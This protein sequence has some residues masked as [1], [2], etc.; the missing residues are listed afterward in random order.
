MLLKKIKYSEHLGEPRA[1][2]LEELTL[3]KVNLFV[4]KN[5]CG[6][7]RILN[8][9]F[10]IAK[11]LSQRLRSI[12]SGT[13]EIEI[14]VDDK[15]YNYFIDIADNQI[16]SESYSQG[17]KQLLS[18]EKDGTGTILF[19][20]EDDYKE[21]QIS[22]DQIAAVAKLDLIQHP[23]LAPLHDWASAVIHYS[24]GTDMGRTSLLIPTNN[25]GEKFS[26]TQTDKAVNFMLQGLKDFGD[27]FKSAVI[28][29]LNE[30]GYDVEDVGTAAP[31]G[32]SIEAPQNL[33]VDDI[34]GIFVKE[35]AI[36][37]R[38]EQT[39]I[40]QGMFRAVAIICELN[41]MLLSKFEGCH[42]IDDIGEGLDFDRSSSLIE[43]VVEKALQGSMQ[44][45]M[46]TNDRFVMNA[47]P[48]EYWSL[49]QRDGQTVKALTHKNSKDKF[50]EFKFTGLSNF[51]LYS[52]DFLQS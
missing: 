45:L 15:T 46:S 19:A 8:V 47:I 3:D 11:L 7:S 36:E 14:E 26:I 21:F 40:S 20:T 12:S 5:A 48:L 4:G 25:F 29:D 35:K 2:E 42:L 23:F 1:W 17:E 9:I 41:Y 6:K 33:S 51:D 34:H 28:H 37:A 22:V 43:L 24:F 44:L 49:L 50:E 13:F 10:S 16:V 32:V 38:V 52:S 30:I 18:R 27:D 31:T 39:N